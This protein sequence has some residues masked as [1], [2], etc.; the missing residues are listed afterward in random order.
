MLRRSATFKSVTAARETNADLT[1]LQVGAP[2]ILQD[3]WPAPPSST[4]R[5]WLRSLRLWWL[6]LR[7]SATETETAIVLSMA[8]SLA[9]ACRGAVPYTPSA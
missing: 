3:D 7:L 5:S 6:L 1:S 8:A 9:C 4:P 2:T